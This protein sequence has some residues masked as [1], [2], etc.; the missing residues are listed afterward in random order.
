MSESSEPHV[1]RGQ[2]GVGE[3]FIRYRSDCIGHALPNPTTS[4]HP[5]YLATK[6]RG[7][8]GYAATPGS[9][10]SILLV[11]KEDHRT[12]TKVAGPEDRTRDLPNERFKVDTCFGYESKKGVERNLVILKIKPMNNHVH[13]ELSRPFH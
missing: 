1:D 6:S 7:L 12:F 5:L 3:G 8:Q 13:R 9:A 2:D 10:P 11:V 4:N